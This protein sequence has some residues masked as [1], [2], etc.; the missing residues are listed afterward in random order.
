[1][2]RHVIR[3]PF[4]IKGTINAST[5]TPTVTAR[6]AATVEALTSG[7][8]FYEVPEGLAAAKFRFSSDDSADESIVLDIL[9][10]HGN[11]D[12]KGH[13]TRLGTITLTVGT[14]SADTTGQTFC[15]AVVVSNDASNQELKAISTTDNYIGQ[16]LL[17]LSGQGKLA[18][19]ATTLASGKL[20]NIEVCKCV[21][22]HDQFKA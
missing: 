16:A 12:R 15:D 21:H 4:E 11:E 10:R 2:S 22:E 8:Y 3:Q 13:Y 1:M 5:T 14:Q 18:F 20:V 19:V 6:D 17:N 9:E 7:V